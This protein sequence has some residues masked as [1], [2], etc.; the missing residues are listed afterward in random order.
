MAVIMI[1]EFKN[2]CNF[3]SCFI[4]SNSQFSRNSELDGTLEKTELTLF[5]FKTG[6]F[7][8]DQPL[9]FSGKLTTADGTRIGNSEIIIKSD[10]FLYF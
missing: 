10:H 9:V 5:D 3:T 4:F 2:Y 1:F 8:G 7:A 6:K